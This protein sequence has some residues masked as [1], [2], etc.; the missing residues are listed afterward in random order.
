MTEKGSVSSGNVVQTQRK[1]STFVD[2]ADRIS[3]DQSQR[4]AEAA[5]TSSGNVVQKER[6]KITFADEAGGTLCHVRFFEDDTASF[7]ESD[8]EKEVL[9]AD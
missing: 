7:S 1:K 5:S 6:K 3:V 2:E 4:L 9:L 8:T